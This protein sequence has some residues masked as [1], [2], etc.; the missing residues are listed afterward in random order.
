MGRFE[1]MVMTVTGPI[2]PKKLGV[3]LMHE[4]LL[5]NLTPF[6][7]KP[8]SVSERRFAHEPVGIRLLGSIKSND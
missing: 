3:T 2:E 1:G 8:K 4:H 7:V 5:V 6:S